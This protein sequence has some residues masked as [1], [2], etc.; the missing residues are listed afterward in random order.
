MKKRVFALILTLALILSCLT[1]CSAPENTVS[2]PVLEAADI[3]GI[4][5]SVRIGSGNLTASYPTDTWTVG[6]V[7]NGLAMIF[8]NETYGT[9][10]AVNI[11][12][13]VNAKYSL[14]LTEAVMED[15]L[16]NLDGSGMTVEVSEMRTLNGEP[17]IYMESITQITDEALD[18]MV[19]E[20]MITEDEITALGGREFLKSIPPTHTIS[21]SAIVDGWMCIYSGTYYDDAHY[22]PVLDAM[23]VLIQT[24]AIEK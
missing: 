19:E 22:Q 17:V 20:G 9:S 8:L 1:A 24:S 11:N 12:M 21:I 15:I 14:P 4:D 23:T 2:Y 3:S 6:G 5:Q 10:S 16:K 18:L 7:N 13:Q